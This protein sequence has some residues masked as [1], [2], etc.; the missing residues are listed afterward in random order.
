MPGEAEWRS[1]AEGPGARR[2]PY[3]IST[4]QLVCLVVA[5]TTCYH[6]QLFGGPECTGWNAHSAVPV[7]DT[8]EAAARHD[9]GVR[10]A[11]GRALGSFRF[12]AHNGLTADITPC[13]L[14]AS[15]ASRRR[16]EFLVAKRR[17]G[18]N[19]HHD[20]THTCGLMALVASASDLPKGSFKL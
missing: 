5:T 18:R 19:S 4:N 12:E 9:A 6:L 14:C 10:R 20:K 16:F 7:F 13:P 2:N 3:K 17:L 15:T 1:L 11:I 8:A